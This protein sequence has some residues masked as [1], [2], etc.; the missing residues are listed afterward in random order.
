MHQ[1]FVGLVCKLHRVGDWL[2]KFPKLC[3]S[4][5]WSGRLLKGL[6]SFTYEKDSKLH[7]GDFLKNT[8]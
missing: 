5:H 4:E 6:Q 2:A 7:S 8:H 3:P 1:S